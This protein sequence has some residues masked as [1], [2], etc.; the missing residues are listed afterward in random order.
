MKRTKLQETSYWPGY[1][2]ALVN[3]VLNI[4]FLVGLMAVGLVSLNV[5]ALGNFKLAGQAKQLQ[6]INEDNLILAALGTL[7]A[8]LPEVPKPSATAPSESFFKLPV[9]SPSRSIEPVVLR[10]G[11]P[12]VYV[13]ATQEHAFLQSRSET[14]GLVNPKV[15]EF[16]GMQYMLTAAQTKEVQ[17]LVAA[18]KDTKWHLLASVPAQDERLGREAFGR[19]TSVREKLIAGGAKPENIVMSTVLQENTNFSNGRRV[20]IYPRQSTSPN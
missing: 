13:P 16:Q 1:V 2:D 10:V 5:E 7:L 6:K 20:F 19:L 18:T 17:L 3:V 14:G 15:M 4:L 11:K 8:A 9:P 12:F